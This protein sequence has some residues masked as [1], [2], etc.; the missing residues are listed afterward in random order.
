MELPNELVAEIF[1]YCSVAPLLVCGQVNILWNCICKIRSVWV[2]KNVKCCDRFRFISDKCLS[3]MTHFHTLNLRN[4][5]ISHNNIHLLRGLYKLNLSLSNITNDDVRLLGNIHTLWLANVNINDVSTL[6]KLHTL[7]LYRCRKIT[8]ISTLGNLYSL[9]LSFSHWK[10]GGNIQV[11]NNLHTLQIH[12]SGLWQD[13]DIFRYIHT[14]YL[15]YCRKMPIKDMGVFANIHTLNFK[16]CKNMELNG[17]NGIKNI[18]SLYLKEC[19]GWFDV[20][21]LGNLDTLNLTGTTHVFG[22]Q[23]LCNVRNLTLQNGNVK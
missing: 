3:S 11:L 5:R 1:N 6:G 21:P 23:Y 20:S 8:D 19:S 10:K 9:C 15:W 12:M 18:H 16:A 2:H 4:K 13:V 17:M 22:I 7:L 14:L